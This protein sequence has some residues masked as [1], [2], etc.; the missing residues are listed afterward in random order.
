M[1]ELTTVETTAI[2]TSMSGLAINRDPEVVLAE[3]TKA[4]KALQRVVANKAKPVRFNNEQYLEF[5]DWLTVARFYG[6]TVKVTSTSP[7]EIGGASG[8]EARAVVI[9]NR[10]GSEVSAA[11]SM[12]MNDEPN[13]AKKPLFQ[14]RSMA[15]TRVCAKALRNVLAWVVVLAGFKAT[16]A[17][18]M[19]GVFQPPVNAKPPTEK[20]KAKTPAPAAVPVASMTI[21]DA[22]Q[23]SVGTVIG[24]ISGFVT[25][26]KPRKFASGKQ[27][28]DYTIADEENTSSMI[29][30]EWREPIAGIAAGSP[31]E[32]TNVKVSDYNGANQYTA[33]KISG[34]EPEIPF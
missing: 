4:A 22:L 3:A 6:L 28:T 19:E 23:A 7:I 5:E 20:P 12:C 18:E 24:T 9:D 10:T 21:A 33:E 32:A 1:N 30:S 16:P 34:T 14:L 25:E 27:K 2:E 11:E 31:I 29:V 26:I 15:Q 17:E 8:F 13:W